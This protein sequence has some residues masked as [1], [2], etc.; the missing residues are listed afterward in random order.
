MLPL[1]DIGARFRLVRD[2]DRYPH[3][4]CPAGSCGTVTDTTAGNISLRMDEYLPG[5]EEWANE[6]LWSD[7]FGERAAFWQDTES[8]S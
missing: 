5:A 6:I 8:I 2:V 4:I 7:D 3:F 1:P